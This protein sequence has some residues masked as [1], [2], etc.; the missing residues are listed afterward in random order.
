M[1]KH[2]ADRAFFRRHAGRVDVVVGL[3][4][5][6]VALSGVKRKMVQPPM[7]QPARYLC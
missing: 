6:L 7:L 3:Q 4:R 5:R 1:S 2:E